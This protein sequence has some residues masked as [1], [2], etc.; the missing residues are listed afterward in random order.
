ML[1]IKKKWK[2]GHWISLIQLRTQVWWIPVMS[3]HEK[4]KDF[5]IKNYVFIILHFVMTKLKFTFFCSRQARLDSIEKMSSSKQ[6]WIFHENEMILYRS[7]EF[8]QAE[9][10]QSYLVGI[11]F[12]LFNLKTMELRV[13]PL[14]HHLL[15]QNQF[16]GKWI[17]IFLQWNIIVRDLSLKFSLCKI[18]VLE[19]A[20]KSL[21]AGNS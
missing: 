4:M 17:F 1:K 18:L 13:E 21:E 9:P 12:I 14:F 20:C 15:N 3:Y 8:E 2:I 6:F 11:S 10:I 16:F 7:D 19:M 5:N